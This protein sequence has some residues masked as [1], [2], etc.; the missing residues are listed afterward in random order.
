MGGGLRRGVCWHSSWNRDGAKG[1]EASKS[2]KRVCVSGWQMSV[3]HAGSGFTE[4]LQAAKRG[5]RGFWCRTFRR[6]LGLMQ[7]GSCSVVA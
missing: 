2:S 4:A 1:A 7:A 6:V 5:V 3:L